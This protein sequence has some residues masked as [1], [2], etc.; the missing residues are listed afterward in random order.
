MSAEVLQALADTALASSAAVLLVRLLRKPLRLVAGARAAYS[1]S[2][3]VS[4]R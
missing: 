1:Y 2:D 4:N 3:S